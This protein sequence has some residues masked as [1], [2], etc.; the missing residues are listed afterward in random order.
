MGQQ[1]DIQSEAEGRALEGQA[2]GGRVAD[3]G[4][5]SPQVQESTQSE[6]TSVPSAG[7]ASRRIEEA[8]AK[9]KAHW[10]QVLRARADLENE[11]RRFQRDLENAHKFALERFALALLPVK[12]SLELGLSAAAE[13]ADIGKLREGMDLTLK[14]LHGVMEKFGI[15]E[16]N[17][18]GEKFDPQRHES[19]ASQET[20]AVE[21]NT[22]VTVY[23]K[24]YSLN[25]RL[26]RPAL[27]VISKPTAANIDERA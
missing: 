24:G 12:D 20:S 19:M 9:A 21:P 23:Q 8:E 25:D 7:D 10:D 16:I 6:G 2:E 11:R 14:M 26:L 5:D 4:A 27:V 1:E 13:S 17:P 22:V 18:V 3:R 15:G